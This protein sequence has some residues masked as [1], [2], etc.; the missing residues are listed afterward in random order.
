M[1]RRKNQ[2]GEMKSSI[3]KIGKVVLLFS[4]VL[5]SVG[6]T[7]SL[8]ANLSVG[9]DSGYPGDLV[10]PIPI[11]L[12]NTPT[13]KA[14]AIQLDLDYDS[15]RLEFQSVE[16]GA[17]AAA[18]GKSISFSPSSGKVLCLIYGLNSNE[19]EDGVVA[20]ATFR[21]IDGASPG[22]ASL[23]LSNVILANVAGGTI[24]DLTLTPGFI[25]CLGTTTYN[26]NII[27]YNGTVAKNPDYQTYDPGTVVTLT[28]AAD[29]GYSFT[30]WS[31]DLTG[32]ANP[33]T[34]VMD[35]NKSITAN[36]S[37]DLYTLTINAGNG[38]VAKDPDKASYS[39]DEV[40]TLTATPDLGYS[41][42][43][44]SGDLS[45]ALNPETIVMDGDKVVAANFNQDTYSLSIIAADGAVSK[46]PDKANYLYGEAVILTANPDTGYSFTN[47]SGDLT[48]AENPAVVIM[49]DDKTVTA[50]FS[51]DVYTLTINA[52]GGSVTKNPDQASYNY[53][54]QV[55]LN[56]IPDAGYSFTNWSGDLSG[57]VNPETLAMDG[58][59][60]ITA[61]FSQDLYTLAISATDG[62]VAKDPDKISYVYGE[63]VALSATA[64]I[65]YHFVN[66]SGDL[67]GASNPTNITMNANK[68]LSANFTINTYALDV[69]AAN[70]S[71]TKDPDKAT[72]NYGEQVSLTAFPDQG[73]SFANWSGDLT[74]SNNPTTILIDGDKILTANFSQNTH[75]L[76]ILA[77]NG[78]VTKAP[79]KANYI[80]GEVVTLTANPDVGYS[81]GG[82]S[83]DLSG[84]A[85]PETIVMDGNKIVT[86][87][88]NQDTYS[89]TVNAVNGSVSRS[90]DRTYVYGDQVTLTA[91]PDTGYAF[92]HW[93]GDL[94]GSTNP[95]TIVIDGDKNV[96]ANFDLLGP[97]ATFDIADGVSITKGTSGDL[98]VNLINAND[99]QIAGF[100]MDISYDPA[101]ISQI[102]AAAGSSAT[103][104]GKQASSS[105]P[106]EGILRI[107]V[108]GVNTN[109]IGNGEV[110]ILSATVDAGAP[111]GTSLLNIETITASDASGTPLP[112]NVEGGSIV[113]EEAPN[114]PPVA[115]DQEVET[116]EDTPAAITLTGSDSDK[117]SLTYIIVTS[118]IHGSLSGSAPDLTYALDFNYNGEDSFT[119]KVNDGE[120][121]SNIATVSITVNPVNDPPVLEPIGNKS[122]TEGNLLEFDISAI[123]PDGDNLTYL[124]AP[125][126][127]AGASLNSATGQF[128]W[129]PDYHQAGTYDVGFSASDGSLSDSGAISIEVSDVVLN[130]PPV[131]HSQ[132]QDTNEDTPAAI[133]LTGSDPDGD[134]LTYILVTS[135]SHGSLSGSAPDLTYAPD[136]GYSGADEFTFKVNDGNTDS[137]I[138]TVSITVKEVNHPPVAEDLTA[139]TRKNKPVKITLIASDEDKDNLTY[140]ITKQPAHGKVTLSG[141]RVTYKPEKNYV[142][143]DTFRYVASDGK[144]DSNEAVVT[145]KIVKVNN[146]PRAHGKSVSIK[147]N[148][149]VQIELSGEDPDGDPL[150]YRI[151]RN[152][153]RGRVSL[154]GKTATYTPN[155]RIRMDSFE[156]VVNDGELDSY[157]TLVIIKVFAKPVLKPKI[158]LLGV[159][160]KLGPIHVDRNGRF[161]IRWQNCNADRYVVKKSNDLGVLL[162]DAWGIKPH[163]DK[164]ETF[165][166]PAWRRFFTFRNEP[167]GSNVFFVVLAYQGEE[168]KGALDGVRI[169]KK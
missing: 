28:A 152:P 72:Y 113:V 138:A 21:I 130:Q 30:G 97:Q 158:K 105:N 56:A 132:Q 92:S 74:G 17:S 12:T 99:P 22:D 55:G 59:K 162:Q 140:R 145:I 2:E 133:T 58:D 43:G 38:S 148:E 31:G 14:G 11:T 73:Y 159:E 64:D 19:I 128:T 156:Y 60:V 155:E 71:V 84:A 24:D 25:S 82:W 142:G 126:L 149:T 91:L 144:A 139:K 35:G 146:R 7:Q 112:V 80:Y 164:V 45:G 127:P 124:A 54:D 33:E 40:V 108:Y 44:W 61:N 83:G 125:P 123:D 134:A 39:Y 23:A 116:N 161:A 104:A 122:V 131:A 65:G 62:S 154:E 136:S 20:L 93:S 68:T 50:N 157:K 100:Q 9:E 77:A 90:P 165:N 121:D 101:V 107:L 27:T 3:K 75:T 86:A 29:L 166:L 147:P 8:A 117:D 118:P 67:S 70:G 63:V 81:F 102:S 150:T 1:Y 153:Y 76:T 42:G 115:Y 51:Q 41:F 135:P 48:N 114:E 10:A 98:G 18:A 141:N 89:L 129:T 110:V 4:A 6:L 88:F 37:Q 96:T 106:A 69:S 163:P 143:T 109:T 16:V 137:N 52:A 111:L 103:A 169:R 46:N 15:S 53:G 95:E 79:D 13:N 85:N 47:W 57:T 167:K 168:V 94:S 87:N 5:L 34:I 160:F 120:F 119:F 66:W 49:D 26:L 78:S 151:T 32:S 36:F